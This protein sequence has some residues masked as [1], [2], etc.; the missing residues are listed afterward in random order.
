MASDFGRRAAPRIAILVRLI[1]L[2]LAAG[3]VGIAPAL[4]A[5]RFPVDQFR[6]YIS[7]YESELRRLAKS[8]DKPLADLEAEVA[9]AEA[10]GNPRLAAASLEKIV[11]LSPNDGPRW[12]KLAQLLA[13]AQP[14]DD[15]DGY[16]LP[17]RL[18]GA[19][20]KAYLLA[21]AG[22]V[23]AEALALA[24]QGFGK[25]DYWRPALTAY[26]E[27]LRLVE[28]PAN[29]AAYDQMRLDHGFRVTDYKIENDAI[30]P[31]ACF[32]LSDPPSRTV[33]DFAPYFRQEPGPLS[34]VS[35]EGNRLCVEGLK[36]GEHYAITLRQ[37]LPS[38]VEEDLPR[39]YE[40]RFYVRDRAPAVRFAGRSYVLPRTGQNGIPVIT[41]NT[42]SV[43]LT[44][45][46][47]GDRS[48]IDNVLDSDFL[49]QIDGYAARDIANARGALVWEGSL[50]TQTPLNE[51]ITTAFPVAEAL[52]EL[53]PGLYVMTARP[54]AKVPPDDYQNVATQWF[55]VSDLGLATLDGKDGLH[56]LVRSI[57]TAEAMDGVEVR[58]IARNNEVL[59]T[60]TTAGGA[61]R[62]EPGLMRG[63][64]G[65]E[66]ALVVARSGSSDYSFLD[67]TQPAFDLTDRGVSGREPPGVVDAFVY[68]ER[69]VY[70]RGE[71]VHATVLLR[72]A[73]AQAMTGVP[74]TVVV[75]RS[76]GVEYSRS[77][78]DD[79]GAGGMSLDIPINAAASGGTWRIRAY[80]DP[81]ADQVGETSF[82]VED[83]IP[84]RIEF[85]LKPAVEKASA[86]EGARFTV[87]GRYLFG[88]PAAGLDL[89]A[90]ISVGVDLAPFAQWQG[91]SF[92]LT[93]ERV[94]TVQTTAEGL[95]QTDINGH[96]EFGLRLPELP[97]T[98]RPLRA[99]VAVRLREPGGRAVE[100]RASLPVAAEQPLFG[101][102]P[103]F[104]SGG[105]P[106]GEPAEFDA[107]ALD[108]AG[109]PIAVKGADWTL[110]RLTVD[111]QWFNVDGE[112]R[113]ESV[114]H[115]AKI[116]GGKLDI[117]SGKPARLSKTL[118][119]GIY[120]LEIGADGMS[121]AS[122]DFSAGYYYNASA[123]ADTPDSLGVAL[124][125][126]D[127][128]PGETLNVKIDSRFAGKAV[129]QVV[130]DR[131]LASQAIEVPEGGATVPVTV[132][133]EWGTG[134]YV[135]ATL[136]R[137]MDVVAKRMPARAIG[138]AWFG[139]DR[140]AR[141]LG[142]TLATPDMMRPRQALA[143]PVKV[144]GLAPGEEAYVTVAAVDVGILNLTRYQP[145]SPET[146]YYEQKRLSA[147]LRDL[148]GVLIDG[149]QGAKGRI[150]SGGDAAEA[151]TAPPPTQPPLSLFSGIVKVAGDGTANVAFDIPAFNGTV[152]VM[153]V[154][155]SAGKVGHAATD[156]IARDPVVM[157]G[158]LPRFLAVGDQSRLRLDIINTEAPAGDYS[159][160]VSVEGPIGAPSAA[161]S[162][163][164]T[165]GAA[166]GKIAALVPISATGPGE[167]NLTAKLVGPGDV[168]V[169]QTYAL[170]IVPAN[171]LV[172]RRT[173]F[174]LA[175][176][177]GAVTLSRDLL[178]EMVPGTSAVSLS[179]SPLAELDAAGLI[180]D[181]DRYP[182]GCSEQ[183]VSRALPLLYLSELGAGEGVL[184]SDLAQRM[185]VAVA[186]LLNRQSAN[187]SFGVWT[188][189][190]SGDNLWISAFVTDFLLRAREKGYAVP[191][192]QLTDAVDYLR[193]TVGNAPDIADGGG[194]D[195][196]YA[197]YVLA[198][199]GRAPVGDLKY[200]ADTKIGSFGSAMAKAQVAA[201][202]AMLGDSAR[203]EAAF[204]AAV[205]SLGEDGQDE[206]RRYRSDYG[207]VLRDASAILALATDAKADP[208]IVKAALTTVASERGKWSYASTQEMAWMVLAARAAAAQARTIRLDAGGTPETGAFYKLFAD[209]EFTGDYRLANQGKEPLR[210]VVAVSGSPLT[211]EPAASN[212]ITVARSYYTPDG[213]P[214]DPAAVKQNT[215]LVVVLDVN[216]PTGEP[217]GTF[218]LTDR[219]PAGL[220]IENPSLVYSGSTASLAWLQETGYASYTEFRDD[221]FVASFGQAPLRVA[222]MV[223]AVAPGSYAHPGAFVE[224]MYR[225]EINARTAS[226]VVTVTE[227]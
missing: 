174:E 73:K 80:T 98:T 30:P 54:G 137:P 210:A 183:T 188:A 227:P 6:Y 156:V 161:L 151:F 163:K 41:V 31:R 172:T 64:G 184:D 199:A 65:L 15:S 102:K 105:A 166:G 61:V 20:L 101:I 196:A 22:P 106:E 226:G 187:G 146:Y 3:I 69:G 170:N 19:G 52:T 111:Y 215:R 62:F 221:R 175:A 18:I 4:A 121:P 94:D 57:A 99:D 78:L 223:R 5:K 109:A 86:A 29:R 2:V 135:V 117:E 125:R 67:L 47:I 194:Q 114:T 43:E 35:V 100:N 153:A 179:V 91:Y 176:N 171:P 95:P 139:I 92:G 132:G 202:L 7:D 71:T 149:M 157:A 82:L 207:S 88:A 32:D 34:A 13:T 193:N 10:A 77:V 107:I 211:P 17:S 131:L 217:N 204:A 50:E 55:V 160:E 8:V 127:V 124:D 208:R 83:Y 93:D 142:V 81:E 130:G 85:D 21:S 68:A 1:L 51:E 90:T 103:A 49:A 36:F 173:T 195:V 40:Y 27:S 216:V 79:Q 37:G 168:A 25:R 143:V 14:I 33:A 108:A 145:P 44:L 219:L 167:A 178:A 42:T 118:S 136:I 162:Q 39:D 152:R 45:Y 206:V 56:V 76:D 191:E 97:S 144:G 213:Q 138:V 214:V 209:G 225:P 16:R 63:A 212:G 222:Y 53:S 24:A 128:R 134:A 182:Y 70:R 220:E 205:D 11:A 224:D 119:W 115:A 201:A 59:A 28:D 200:L 12:L 198:R 113:Y 72:D 148:Y 38:A 150:R 189:G 26:R 112:W 129:V 48:L 177:G 190:D 181:L 74:V 110:K 186:R 185:E 203:A 66:P 164:V 155:W 180:R 23:E 89:E 75:E 58:L 133:G 218:L 9:A 84:D 123:K 60:A 197:L 104:D 147:D 116:A 159:L 87:D 140:E 169:E 158:T 154:A 165:L 141:T 96:A 122:V 120:R 192:A 126:T 46:R